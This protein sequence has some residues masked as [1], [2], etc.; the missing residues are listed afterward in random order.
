LKKLPGRK[1]L[2][3]NSPGWVLKVE[4]LKKEIDG[5]VWIGYNLP[6]LP[7]KCSRKRHIR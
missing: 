2:K 6:P 4:K 5:M 7:R 1:I 3:W